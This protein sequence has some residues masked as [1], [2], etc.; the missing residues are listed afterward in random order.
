VKSSAADVDEYLDEYDGEWREALIQ[1]RS[2]CKTLLAGYDEVM[3][4]G[5]PTY[6]RSGRIEVSFAKQAQ[7][8][9]VYILK[10]AILDLHRA[11]LAGLSVGKG[12]IRYR[13]VDQID[14]N[15][16]AQLLVDT[17]RIEGQPC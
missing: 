3:A 5:M 17:T 11:E 8:L 7:Y 2:T 12:C 16:I 14:W 4:H 13:R 1:L 9:S 15:L 6:G 10:E